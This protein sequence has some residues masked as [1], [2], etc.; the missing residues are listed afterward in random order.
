MIIGTSSVQQQPARKRTTVRGPKPTVGRRI[1]GL[2]TTPDGLENQKESASSRLLRLMKKKSF[3]LSLNPF[4]LP[5]SD[6]SS[7]S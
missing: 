6:G 7:V 2:K 4:V 1:I 5:S 3:V